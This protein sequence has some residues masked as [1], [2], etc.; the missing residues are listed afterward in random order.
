MNILS[1]MLFVICSNGAIAQNPDSLLS[2]ARIDGGKASVSIDVMIPVTT[3]EALVSE[4]PIVVRGTV[5]SVKTRL[6]RDEAF[7]LTEYTIVPLEFYKYSSTLARRPGAGAALT[8]TSFGGVLDIDG[9]HLTTTIGSVQETDILNAGE[10]V[11]LFLSP[12]EREIGAFRFTGGPFGALRV[13][14]GVV[15]PLTREVASRRG[16]PVTTLGDFERRLRSLIVK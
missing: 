13:A 5:G 15:A 9:M 1:L 14:N 2:R 8:V 3:I 10:T 6:S 16:D 7:V 12:D 4:A 11:I